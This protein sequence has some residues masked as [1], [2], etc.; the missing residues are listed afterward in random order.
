MG[1]RCQDSAPA[2]TMPMRNDRIAAALWS[3]SDKFGRFRRRNAGHR[4]PCRTAG[5]MCEA[6]RAQTA[7]QTLLPPAPRCSNNFCLLTQATIPMTSKTL[8]TCQ[9]CRQVLHRDEK[10]TARQQAALRLNLS[11]ADSR[12]EIRRSG[13]G[14]PRHIRALVARE[15]LSGAYPRPTGAAGPFRCSSI[16]GPSGPW[17]DRWHK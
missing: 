16:A 3:T 4:S 2:P 13:R 5:P 15:R 9:I 7:V 8:Q 1:N 12:R 6:R 11:A 17:S 10:K 14:G